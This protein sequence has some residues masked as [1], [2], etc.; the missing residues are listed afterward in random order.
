MRC[1]DRN[2]CSMMRT[3]KKKNSKASRSTWCCS[4]YYV[5]GMYRKPLHKKKLLKTQFSAGTG[6]R[7]TAAYIWNMVRSTLWPCFWFSANKRLLLVDL[8]RSR[9]FPSALFLREETGTGS[10]CWCSP[11]FYPGCVF[12]KRCCALTS[13]TPPVPLTS[14]VSCLTVSSSAISYW[15][16]ENL[17]LERKKQGAACHPRQPAGMGL[18]N[19]TVA[20]SARYMV[21]TQLEWYV[22]VL[23]VVR[24]LDVIF[25]FY[26]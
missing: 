21:A 5:F 3:T 2:G 17:S 7:M 6:P 26:F 18:S 1:T 9:Q 10:F 25:F 13:T 22:D 23:F 24:K 15:P 8:P 12:A 19:V 11:G 4:Y 16:V 14:L 20:Q